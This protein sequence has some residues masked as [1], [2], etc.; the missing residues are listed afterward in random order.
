[1][2]K[3]TKSYTEQMKELQEKLKKR[4]EEIFES[5]PDFDEPQTTGDPYRALEDDEEKKPNK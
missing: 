4:S 2:T 5:G 3:D 1:M